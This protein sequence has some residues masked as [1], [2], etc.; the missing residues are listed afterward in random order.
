[1]II[2]NIN[3]DLRDIFNSKVFTKALKGVKATYIPGSKQK[4]YFEY[5]ELVAWFS[6][7]LTTKKEVALAKKN[8]KLTA[9]R[10]RVLIR[11]AARKIKAE[12]RTISGCDK[13]MKKNCI[14]SEEMIEKTIAKKIRQLEKLTVKMD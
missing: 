7:W 3:D 14:A 4:K 2:I 12:I 5:D 9:N 13:N 11:I 6:Q 8:K 1:M 10:D